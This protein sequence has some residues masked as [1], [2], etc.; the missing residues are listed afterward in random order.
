MGPYNCFDN[1]D[2][3]P[4][5]IDEFIYDTDLEVTHKLTLLAGQ[6]N[7]STYLFLKTLAEFDRRKAWCKAS[8]R[9]CCHWLNWK[10]SISFVTAREKLRVAHCLDKLPLTNKAFASGM[11][12][13]SKVRAI[14][15]I[16]TDE[17]EH[18]LIDIAKGCSASHMDKLVRRFERVD[19]NQQPI[20][21]VD[22]YELRNL[23]YYQDEEGMWII[24]AK[25]PMLEGGLLVKA[26]E[27][28]VRQ[29][30]TIDS[31]GAPNEVQDKQ[32][33]VPVVEKKTSGQKDADAVCSLAEHFIA[34]ATVNE[35]DGIKALAGHER[36]MVVVHINADTL[37]AEEEHKNGLFNGCSHLKP[38]YVD[39]QGISEANAKRFGSDASIY[40]VLE[41]SYGN[42]LNI[43]R[44]SRTVNTPLRRA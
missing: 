20:E 44:K 10:C 1:P 11:L 23:I 24:R 12:S 18:I 6:I 19:K 37:K 33:S 14:T 42:V 43:G 7:A 41:D 8:M 31:A 2:E 35:K 36:C 3:E 38:H 5:P 16:A 28:V 22:E 39:Y 25:L 4:D 9:S 27:E 34:T 29:N 17:N 13:Y 32:Q 40:T 15:R 30:E 26:I 21:Q